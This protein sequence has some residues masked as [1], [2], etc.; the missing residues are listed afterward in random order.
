MPTWLRYLLVGGLGLILLISLPAHR[1]HRTFD[2]PA[3]QL[4]AAFFADLQ[5]LEAEAKRFAALA[6]G[7]APLQAPLLDLRHRYKRVEWLLAHLQPE[8]TVQK[9]NGA[10]LPKIDPMEENRPVVIEPVGLQVMDEWVFDPA[11]TD[12]QEIVALAQGFAQ[13]IELLNQYYRTPRPL[14]DRKFFEASRYALL[15]ILTLGLTGFDTPGSQH[16]LPD[17]QVTLAQVAAVY[18]Q[19]DAPLRARGETALAD[20]LQT[21][22]AGAL[23]FLAQ[24]VSFADFDRVTFIRAYLEPLYGWLLDAQLALGIETIYEVQP[25]VQPVNYHSRHIFASDFLTP[26]AYVKFE[27]RTAP[28]ARI[29][30]GRLLFFDPALSASGERSCASCHQP[31][32]AFADGR[33]KSLATGF[34]GTVARN[35]PTLLNSVFASR[36][37]HD[38]RAQE[39]ETQVDHVVFS[40]EEFDTD[41]AAILRTLQA[42]AEYRQLFEAAY[43]GYRG[44]R[45]PAIN[46]AT[47]KGALAAYVKTLHSFDSPVDRYLRGETDTLAPAVARGFNLFMGKAV[48]GTC[49]F[50]PTFNGTVPPDYRDSESEV[51]GVPA[52]AHWE[53]ATV[54]PDAGRAANGVPLDNASIYDFSFKTPTVR[55]I[56]LTAPYMHNGVYETL[57]EVMRFYQVGGGAG[58]GIDLAHQ[59]LPFDSLDLDTQ[60]VQDIIAFMTALTDTA[61]LTRAPARLPAFPADSPL[62]DRQ[63]GGAY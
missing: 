23:A 47:L 6:Q 38:L 41:Y 37:F 53:S 5:A 54:D 42:S 44:S 26:D 63:V 56:A 1:P 30:L 60:D 27:A 22:F 50:A 14:S 39:L 25:V 29:E 12:R 58:I 34:Q 57:E 40:P 33:V 17:A 21:H 18:A 2:S 28:P 32:Q 46:A 13:E 36:Y 20:S 19:Y 9:L 43:P 49:H 31:G 59:T 24:P 4:A 35:A 61:G 45:W 10:P 62:H 11:H 8:L 55:N 51:L 3:P 52:Q 7:D 48:C 16:A 15:R